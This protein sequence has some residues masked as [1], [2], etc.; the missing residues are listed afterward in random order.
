MSP[1][2]NDYDAI[3]TLIHSTDNFLFARY[4][5]LRPLMRAVSGGFQLLFAYMEDLV[6]LANIRK[7]LKRKFPD[8]DVLVHGHMHFGPYHYR[9]NGKPV[10]RS[11]SWVS[12][13]CPGVSTGLLRY[14]KGRFDRLDLVGEEW[15]SYPSSAR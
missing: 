7:V 6:W 11:G 5:L 3:G 15:V 13:G 12:G 8:A 1:R 14:V 10:Y 9:V 4:P 2:I